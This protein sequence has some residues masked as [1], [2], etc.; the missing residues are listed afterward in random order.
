MITP[1]H[2]A[3]NHYS[4][5]QADYDESVLPVWPLRT[6]DDYRKA[7][8]IVDRL[9]VKGEANLTTAERDQLDIF[10]TL[11]ESYEN[12]LHVIALPELS[13]VDFLKK[14]LEESGMNASELGRLLG[15]RSLGYRLLTGARKLSKKHI[16][17]L[18][19]Y[20]KLDP[21]VFLA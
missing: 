11:I 4:D 8:E 17:T 15:D 14:L 10:S 1:D 6:E 12:T 16:K 3:V 5:I 7:V 21:G 13:S 19:E 18:S 20:F 9:A 2:K